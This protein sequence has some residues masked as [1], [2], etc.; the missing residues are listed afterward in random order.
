MK[1]L[2]LIVA[3]LLC[4]MG[5]ARAEM[6]LW[7]MYDR[8]TAGVRI[9][10]AHDQI[11]VGLFGAW[12]PDPKQPPNIFGAY[13]LYEF[14]AIEVVNPIPLD[15]LPEK[16]TGKPYLGG[17]VTVDLADEGRKILGGPMAGVLI[18]DV[19]AIELR[20][21]LVNGSLEGAFPDE[22]YVLSIGPKIRF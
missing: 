20:Y 6:T 1:S 2:I 22:Q 8:D 9:G 16:L 11:E 19:L 21:Q 15:W 12:R 10:Y 3:L 14:G 18:Q 4:V 17:Y 13:S 7:G 5:T